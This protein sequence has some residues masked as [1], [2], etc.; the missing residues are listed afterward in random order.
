MKVFFIC[1]DILILGNFWEIKNEKGPVCDRAQI[2]IL[3]T[4]I[5]ISFVEG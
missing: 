4:V 5:S 2:C 3:E 1:F